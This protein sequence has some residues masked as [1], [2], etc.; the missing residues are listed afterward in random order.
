MS[1]VSPHNMPLRTSELDQFV[2]KSRKLEKSAFWEWQNRLPLHADQS[3]IK[4]GDWLAY[5]WLREEDLDS[6]CLTFRLF[7]Q[8]Q[9]GLSIRQIAKLVETWP[10]QYQ[11]EKEAIRAA[12][13]NLRGRLSRP[14]VI[15]L[16]AGPQK[17]TNKAFF[18]VLFYGG[19]AHSNPGKRADYEHL[20]NSGLFSQFVFNAFWA[21]L[22]DY[23]NCIQTMA[24][25]IAR[26]VIAS[27]EGYA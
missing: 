12:V 23:R 7:I 16:G 1:H 14:C 19:L 3:R 25:H 4:A 11:K 20:V 26:V 13:E 17:T 21:I 18:D 27:G 9:D 5:E 2:S 6:F 8:D 22:C 24:H 10:S 15:S